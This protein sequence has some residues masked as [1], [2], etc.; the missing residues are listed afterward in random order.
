VGQH[1]SEVN[2]GNLPGHLGHLFARFL[3]LFR[4]SRDLGVYVIRMQRH[5]VPGIFCL[6]GTLR[7]FERRR[8]L[9]LRQPH[10]LFANF[11][12]AGWSACAALAPIPGLTPM[13]R[14]WSAQRRVLAVTLPGRARCLLQDF[15]QPAAVF[16]ADGEL[17]EEQPAA[18]TLLG[19]RR[20]ILALGAGRLARE[21]SLN[22]SVEGRILGA[23]R[24]F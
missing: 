11:L 16:T 15:D 21:A 23:N 13:R 8:D 14:Y 9:S 12:G 7:K 22:G 24:E 1:N 17:S 20:D 18:K 2:A 3:A 19:K 10:R 6:Q 4:K 5:H